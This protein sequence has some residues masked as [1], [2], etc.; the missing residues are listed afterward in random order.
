VVSGLRCD[1]NLVAKPVLAIGS[2]LANQGPSR[3]DTRLMITRAGMATVGLGTALV[4]AAYGSAFLP[5]GAP[6][7]AAWF[8][9][10]GIALLSVGL[11]F[12]GAARRGRPLG[13]LLSALAFTFVVLVA[14]FGFALVLPATGPAG[15]RLWGGL[16]IRAAVVLY[17]I[18]L[19]PGLVLPLVYAR[20]FATLTLDQEDVDRIR[21]ARPDPRSP[22]AGGDL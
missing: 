7:W 2:T 15:V 11:M 13:L 5:G 1:G 22:P 20:T 12:L 8:M 9:I 3:D 19:L 18:G 14:G 16:P 17:G 4:A 10:V 21:A 6:R